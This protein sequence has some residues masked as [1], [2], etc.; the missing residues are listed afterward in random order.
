MS[1]TDLHQLLDRDCV[2]PRFASQHI[3]DANDPVARRIVDSQRNAVC[4]DTPLCVDV[5]GIVVTN[6]TRRIGDGD[7]Q[8]MQCGRGS[9]GEA[10]SDQ[11]VGP[12]R[13]PFG[14]RDLQ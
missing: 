7:I 4:R 9:A 3:G 1:R 11:D 6:N 14:S 13:C 8:D 5:A 10:E 2:R 12:P